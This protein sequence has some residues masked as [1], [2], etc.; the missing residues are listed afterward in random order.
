MDLFEAISGRRSIRSY[1]PDPIPEE[2]LSKVMEAAQLAPSAANRQEYRFIVVRDEELRRTLVPACAN[3]G[4]IAEAPIVL[5]GCSTNPSRRYAFVDVAIAMDH[6]TLAAHSLGLGTCWIGAFN[7][8]E[9]KNILGIPE[10]VS[11]VCLM[12]L[13][14]PAKPGT[15]RPRKPLNELFVDNKWA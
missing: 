8:Q 11:V 9:V 10:S 2:A 13:G 4:F 1:K 7:E 3:Q 14:Y 5:V 6:I 12:P 15:M